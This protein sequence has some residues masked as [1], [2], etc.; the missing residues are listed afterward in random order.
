MLPL[1]LILLADDIPLLRRARGWALDWMARR[2]PHRFTAAAG[3]GGATS[4]AGSKESGCSRE[5]PP[6]GGD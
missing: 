2:R 3:R 1:G 6:P 4:A 5:P